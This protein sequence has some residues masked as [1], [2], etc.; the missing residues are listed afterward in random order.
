MKMEEYG[1]LVTNVGKYSADQNNYQDFETY[2]LKL[3]L[4][5]LKTDNVALHYKISLHG[6]EYVTIKENNISLHILTHID[7]K[8][9]TMPIGTPPFF[10][11]KNNFIAP[12]FIE[13]TKNFKAH[14]A[15]QFIF[16]MLF[17]RIDRINPVFDKAYSHHPFR[18]LEAY[19]KKHFGFIDLSARSEIEAGR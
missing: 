1:Y 6:E 11:I 15:T 12:F 19:C 7:S 4:P 16:S 13:K 5:T 2:P 8:P 14:N 3:G 17:K 10:K 18:E 9:L